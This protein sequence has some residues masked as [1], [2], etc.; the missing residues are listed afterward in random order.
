MRPTPRYDTKSYWYINGRP[1]FFSP[2]KFS[3]WLE[4]Q[5]DMNEMKMKDKKG[6]HPFLDAGQLILLGLL[7]VVRE[8]RKGFGYESKNNLLRDAR[9]NV[10]EIVL[11]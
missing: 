8:G 10:L 6:E 9:I 3:S 7:Q 4:D 11:A 5:D 2:I 1:Q